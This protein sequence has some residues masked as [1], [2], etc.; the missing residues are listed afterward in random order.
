MAGKLL[1]VNIFVY[2]ILYVSTY[3]LQESLQIH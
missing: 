2:K 3:H 1:Q